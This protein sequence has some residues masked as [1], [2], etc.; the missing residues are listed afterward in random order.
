MLTNYLKIALKTFSRNRFYTLVSLFGISFTLMVLMLATAFMDNEWGT[1]PPLSN[2]DK[3]LIIPHMD[4][5]TW[6]RESS[7]HLDTI[8]LRDSMIVDTTVTE[9][10]IPGVQENFAS[11]NMS[12]NFLK[13]HISTMKSPEIVSIYAPQIPTEVFPQEI[14]MALSVNMVDENYWKIFDFDF[15]EGYPH[16][17]TAIDNQSRL[18]VLTDHTALQYFG[19]RESYLGLEVVRGHEIYEVIGVVRTPNSSSP[20]VR[21]DAFLPIT[22]MP[23]HSLKYEFGYFG[24][25]HAAL[26][27]PDKLSREAMTRELRQIEQNMEMVDGFD[28]MNFWEKS[29]ADLYAWPVLGGNNE[30]LGKTLVWIVFGTLG[31]FVLIPIFNLINLNITRILERSSEIGVRKAFGA[32]TG[33]LLFQFVYENVLLTLAGGA[34][35]FI[36]S[37]LVMRW[38]NQIEILGGTMLEFNIKIFLKS[39]AITILFGILSGLLPAWKMARKEIATTLKFN[40]I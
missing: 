32:H 25:C 3:L 11:A 31:L 14:R 10:P 1:N 40:R 20:A 38:F 22:L 21:A 16:D 39:L 26:R 29:I 13:D 30:R 8:Y 12:Y 37:I 15:M 34:L 4:M 23:P 18:I 28:V 36:F 33:H 19:S 2:K 6:K 17:K 24:G 9:V 35:G 5:R 27:A 7:V